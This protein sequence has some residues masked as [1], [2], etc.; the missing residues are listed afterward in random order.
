KTALALNEYRG[1][2]VARAGQLLDECPEDLRNWE[3]HYL[4]RLCHGEL[5]TVTLDEHAGYEQA[6]FS[7][8]ARRLALV[9]TKNVLHVYDTATGKETLRIPV[10]GKKINTV[11]LSPDGKRVGICGHVAQERGALQVWDAATGESLCF[12]KIQTPE[13]G[14]G[15]LW[16]LAFS[17]DG[18]HVAT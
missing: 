7:A 11:R 5:R 18:A 9:D 4:Q 15:Q 8:D 14:G 1:N 6:A 13:E 3:W 10:A 17:P 16:G 2:N 12:V